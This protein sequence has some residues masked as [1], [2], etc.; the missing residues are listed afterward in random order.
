MG[1][2]LF[3]YVTPSGFVNS[4]RRFERSSYLRLQCRG[5]I[6]FMTLYYLCMLRIFEWK[7]HSIFRVKQFK[8]ISYT[9]GISWPCRWSCCCPWKC[10]W[11]FAHQHL[12]TYQKSRDCSNTALRTSNFA[13][14]SKMRLLVT[15]IGPGEWVNIFCLEGSEVSPKHGFT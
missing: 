15:Y 1:I 3:W 13:I 2:L 14:Y 10:R 4:Y 9:L 8:K 5:V 12:E 11:L 6:Y 7:T